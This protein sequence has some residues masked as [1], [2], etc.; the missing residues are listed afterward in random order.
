MF[1]VGS[2]SGNPRAWFNEKE[3]T[4]IDDLHPEMAETFRKLISRDSRNRISAQSVRD[5]ALKQLK[6]LRDGKSSSPT[7]PSKASLADRELNVD[8]ER[9]ANELKTI[10]DVLRSIEKTREREYEKTER[11]LNVL[12]A[13]SKLLPQH[14]VRMQENDGR[15]NL[16]LQKNM[17]IREKE[18]Y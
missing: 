7:M 1:D 12:M 2:S 13:L 6:I 5:I 14:S 10:M 18:N 16:K 11:E 9:K 4:H 3:I 8:S 17:H 15:N